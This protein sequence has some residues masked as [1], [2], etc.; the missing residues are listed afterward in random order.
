MTTRAVLIATAVTA[1]VGR[2]VEA[3]EAGKTQF[4][5]VGREIEALVVADWIERDRLFAAADVRPGEAVR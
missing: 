2:S 3:E 1:I 4:V 5:D